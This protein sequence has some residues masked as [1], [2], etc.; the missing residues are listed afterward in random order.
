MKWW[1]AQN[2]V[3][4]GNQADAFADAVRCARAPRAPPTLA[5]P[6]VASRLPRRAAP[7]PLAGSAVAGSEAEPLAPPDDLE[8]A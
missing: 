7:R 3:V 4:L 8:D 6:L 5:L 2:M 1:F